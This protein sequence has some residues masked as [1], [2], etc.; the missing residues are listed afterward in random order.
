MLLGSFNHSIVHVSVQPE[1]AS[2][3]TTM[4]A[5]ELMYPMELVS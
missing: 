2:V 5:L 1:V 4:T 3:V